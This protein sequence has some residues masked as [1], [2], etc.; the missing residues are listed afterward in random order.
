MKIGIMTFHWAINHGALLQAFS[1]QRFL[2]DNIPNSN[3]III[4]YYP[5]KYDKR[6]RRI[7]SSPN[8]IAI[9]NN[10]KEYKKERRIRAFRNSLKMTERYYSTE[11]LCDN[12]TDE[13]VLICGSDQIWN[14]YYTLHGENKVTTAYF[15]PFCPNAVHISYAASFGSMAIKPETEKIIK[16]LLDRFDAISVREQSGVS[17]L[18]NLNIQSELVCDPTFLIDTDMFISKEKNINNTTVKLILRKQN[19]EIQ[20]LINEAMKVVSADNKIVNIEGYSVPKW[21]SSIRDAS[22]LVTNSFHGM[23][24][25]LKFHTPFIVISES[26][27]RSGMNDRFTTL[28]NT[29]GLN[30]RLIKSKE[31]M[32]VIHKRIDW[33]QTDEKIKGYSLKS[34]EYLIGTINKHIIH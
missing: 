1:L 32:D 19:R 7:F 31:Q 12:L 30:D 8:P 5:R 27:S 13:D 29:L 22:F 23:V 2:I 9:I 24:F 10:L 20:E 15:L 4:N 33:C 16:P 26:G 25:A 34:K 3:V 14:E 18:R 28:L 21:L 17:I 6:I 11:E